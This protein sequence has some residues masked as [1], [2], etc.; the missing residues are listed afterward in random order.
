[1]GTARENLRVRA[2]PSTS[3]AILDRLNKGDQFQVVGRTAA[4]D[5]LQIRLPTNPSAHG[6]VSAEF[7]DLTGSLDALP[8]VQPGAPPPPTPRRYP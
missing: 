7:V 5:W 3:A 8:I 2:L 4:R 1:M 6:W